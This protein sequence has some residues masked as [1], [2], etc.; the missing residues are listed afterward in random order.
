MVLKLGGDSGFADYKG[1][2]ES[3]D[4]RMKDF[5][6]PHAI[7]RVE[8]E[9]TV[10]PEPP[11]DV[12]DEIKV[13]IISEAITGGFGRYLIGEAATKEEMKDEYFRG[14]KKWNSDN[15]IIMHLVATAYTAIM[16][17]NYDVNPDGVLEVEA[18]LGT[19]LPV[20]EYKQEDARKE[21]KRK[22]SRHTHTIK[23]FRD[24]CDARFS[25][26]T[27]KIK[28]K[29]VVLGNEAA[30]AHLVLS[31]DENGHPRQDKPHTQRNYLIVVIG[32]GTMEIAPVIKGKPDINKATS[33]PFG[34]NPVI[35]RIRKKLS[36]EDVFLPRRQDFVELALR[37]EDERYQ[38]NKSGTDEIINFSDKVRAEFLPLANAALSNIK[39]MLN[40]FAGIEAI[41]IL[42]GTPV[43]L[44]PY[45]DEV[46]EKEKTK[47][48]LIYQ[49][50]PKQSRYMLA[51]A[52]RRMIEMAE[53]AELLKKG[54][55][56]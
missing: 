17:K 11:Q 6:I 37:D 18:V 36:A 12:L 26:K 23:F 55:N 22:L 38:I 27:V 56:Q 31:R 9:F 13:E 5:S 50:N 28:Y 45:L 47:L 49:D 30:A 21:F 14:R 53:R 10:N 19:G 8:G 43:I 40:G 32:G 25:G 34:V 46:N 54:P 44:R 41:E 4:G 1:V 29:R 51:T 24:A 16:T 35:D 42:G 20:D 15:H 52:Y 48:K 7:Y 33:E 2:Y 39:K 3:A